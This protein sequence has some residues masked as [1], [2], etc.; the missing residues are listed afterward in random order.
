MCRYFLSLLSCFYCHCYLGQEN[1][2]RRVLLLA[3]TGEK[4]NFHDSGG[5]VFDMKGSGNNFYY[6]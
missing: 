1:S 4:W 5:H 2:T 6:R 3:G